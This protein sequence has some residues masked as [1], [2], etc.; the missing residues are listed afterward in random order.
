MSCGFT[1]ALES[2]MYLTVLTNNTSSSFSFLISLKNF[3]TRKLAIF[4]FDSSNFSLVLLINSLRLRR[5]RYS[6]SFASIREIINFTNNQYCSDKCTYRLSTFIC[7]LFC[8]YPHLMFRQV[9]R[10]KHSEQ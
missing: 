8:L 5:A 10:C 2:L 1:Q 3:G 4:F 7:N 9:H 6:F